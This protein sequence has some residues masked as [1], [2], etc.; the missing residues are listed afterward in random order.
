MSGND[1][2]RLSPRAR[3]VLGEIYENDLLMLGEMT[4]DNRT[5]LLR[6]LIPQLMLH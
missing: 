4:H 1:V 5:P 3:M 6:T 2:R